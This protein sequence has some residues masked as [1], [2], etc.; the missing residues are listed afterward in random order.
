M[1]ARFHLYRMTDRGA[2]QQGTPLNSEE[3]NRRWQDL[4]S[5]LNSLE[6][7]SLATVALVN[8]AL[9]NGLRA[10]SD[11][12]AL[13]TGGAVPV[14]GVDGQV[15]AWQGLV[16]LWR[17]LV[18]A[19]ITDLQ[20]L[21]DAK[22]S[23]ADPVLTGVVDADAATSVLVPTP[24]AGDSSTRAANTSWVLARMA[25]LIGAATPSTLNT[26]EEIAD[27]LGDDPN[28]SATVLAL[29]AQAT[30]TSRGTVELATDAET[31]T[32]TDTVR[33]LTPSNLSARIA[34]TAHYLANTAGRLL[35][36]DQVNASGGNY[37]LTDAATIA[38]DMSLGVNFS[39]TLNG[40]RTLG[41]PTN[42]IPG[43]SG[44]FKLTQGASGGPHTL[45]YGN[46][47]VAAGHTFPVLSTAA[48]AVDYVYYDVDTSTRIII[49]GAIKA[50]S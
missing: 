40:D 47:Y 6:S 9:S 45:A 25:E 35:S 43:R 12:M 22:V 5:R 14:G 28:F 46:N 41:N 48:N 32:G 34:S 3:L 15:L 20:A 7:S 44:R 42:A 49:T 10:L 2:G 30:L 19:D 27:A 24:T 38:V 8:T 1:A 37:A 18:A 29:I 17:D 16:Y 31:I 23:A 39:V 21:L 50:V 36:T 11:A 33:G 4:D 26:L 13:I